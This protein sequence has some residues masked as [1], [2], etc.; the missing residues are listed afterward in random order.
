L[1]LTDVTVPT[2]K[3]AVYRIY[4]SPE[5]A[6]K[7]E[8]PGGDGY[9]GT[10]PVVLSSRKSQLNHTR[11]RNAVLNISGRKFETLSRAQGPMQLTLVERGRKESERKPIRVTAADSHFTVADVE[12]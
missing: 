10:L 2:D 12:R 8:G 9:L 7:D 6:R 4:A 11:T 1:H 5:A 3:S